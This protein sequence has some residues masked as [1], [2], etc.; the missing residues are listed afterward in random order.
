MGGL[1]T[2]KKASEE[3]ASMCRDMQEDDTHHRRR[4]TGH[5]ARMCCARDRIR[6]Y[7]PYVVLLYVSILYYDVVFLTSWLW[8][9]GG[10]EE[11]K[12]RRRIECFSKQHQRTQVKLSSFVRSS[13]EGEGK[14]ESS[15]KKRPCYP[16]D[17]ERRCPPPTNG[18]GTTESRDSTV[19]RGGLSRQRHTPDWGGRTAD[20]AT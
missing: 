15:A 14:A 19:R 2:I 17:K 3:Q 20:G 8:D 13:S 6:T 5:C 12:L 7:F 18:R 16:L 1:Y 11:S 4:R 9:G 10:E